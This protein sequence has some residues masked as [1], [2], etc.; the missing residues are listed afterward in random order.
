MQRR[1]RAVCR[2]LTITLVAIIT[3]PGGFGQNCRV[4]T[5]V[6]LVD[7]H[8]FPVSNV[9]SDQLQ[10]EIGGTPAKVVAVSPGDRPVTILLIDISSS[11]QGEWPQSVAAAR[12]LAAAAGDRV[13]AVVFR[14][15]EV[16]YAGDRI[17]TDKLLDQLATIKTSRGGTALY[18]AL[19]DV[20]GRA[21]NRNTA[22]VVISDGEDNA[23]FH[24][25]DGTVKLFLQSSW[26][27]VFGVVLD[28]DRDHTH[29]GNFK[30]IV[31]N[32]GGLIV[33]PSAASKVAE[34]VNQLEAEIN[35]PLL[36]TLEASQP[37]SKPVKLKLEVIG[38][39]NKPRHGFH[40]A[41]VAEVLGCNSAKNSSAKPD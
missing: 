33:L 5:T 36:V 27:P 16:A 38:S 19:I 32:T 35:A 24:S 30:K 10:G 1:M 21:K 26:P 12:Q 18:D 4:T 34:A 6:R 9:T 20:A 22:L 14:E 8:G 15:K 40:V 41:H 29:R 31:A 3:T 13:A 25:S 2:V 39:E 37:I 7:E 11:M 28:Y 23:S 17:D